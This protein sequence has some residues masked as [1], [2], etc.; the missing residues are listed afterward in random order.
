M[1]KCKIEDCTSTKIRARSLCAIHWN[2]E[3]YGDCKNECSQPASSSRGFCTN[4]NKRG[5]KPQTRRDG[6]CSKCNTKLNK[7]LRCPNCRKKEVKNNHLLRHY[8]MTLDQWT[9]ILTS[10]GGFCKICSRDSKRFVV[11][12][13]HSCCS[14]KIS[15]GN[16]I[17]GI[18]CE[19]CNRALGLV[20][21][22]AAILNN[23]IKY[24]EN[25]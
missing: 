13:D 7:D 3:Q 18:I 14:G 8:G 2:R 9:N 4:C 15:C 11:D 21:D 17:R 1:N 6:T 24:L 25:K 10:Q 16:C 22:S 19:N 23:M 20:S 12:H 5:G